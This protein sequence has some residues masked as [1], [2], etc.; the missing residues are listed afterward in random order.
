MRRCATRRL[1]RG[2]AIMTPAGMVV[3]SGAEG[4]A[5]GP[6]D[7]LALSA[8]GLPV[9]QRSALQ[10]IERVSV[11]VARP[12]LRDW[13]ASQSA[14]ALAARRVAA[15]LVARASLKGDD[16]IRLLAWPGAQD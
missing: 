7:F 13:L 5:H 3:F 6:R 9:A 10:A 15:P 8:A 14:P 16:R 4:G 1:R 11:N 12:S 2:D